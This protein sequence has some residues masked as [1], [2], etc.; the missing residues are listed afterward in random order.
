MVLFYL[1]SFGRVW[2]PRIFTTNFNSSD[3]WLESERKCPHS[4]TSY[5]IDWGELIVEKWVL[6]TQNWKWPPAQFYHSH[7][8]TKFHTSSRPKSTL[9]ECAFKLKRY[10]SVDNFS[11]NKCNHNE[12]TQHWNCTSK[13]N[14]PYHIIL[15]SDYKRNK[16]ESQM[17]FNIL[18]QTRTNKL[19]TAAFMSHLSVNWIRNTVF[20]IYSKYRSWFHH[21]PFTDNHPQYI[22]WQTIRVHKRE[23]SFALCSQYLLNSYF[24]CL[25]MSVIYL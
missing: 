7:K 2:I 17:E 11:L 25:N 3:K 16:I 22:R 14:L 20:N 19:S 10:F 5:R 6:N 8:P 9:F 4:Y 1:R 15:I 21:F 12:Q 24:I 13:N 23:A 18:L